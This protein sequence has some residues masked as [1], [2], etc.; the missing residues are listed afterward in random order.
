MHRWYAKAK[1][2]YVYLHDV[3][4]RADFE[5]S[6]WF[7]RGWTLQ[8][9]LAPPKLHFFNNDWRSIGSRAGLIARLETITRIPRPAINAF[10]ATNYC[11]AEKMSWSA[12]RQTTRE[13]DRAYCMLGL[14]GV[15]MPLLYGEGR[16]AFQRLQEEIMKVNTD[17][18]LFLWHG[19]ACDNFG[20][21][22][23]DPVCFADVPNVLQDSSS[24]EDIF[25]LSQGWSINNAG[26][27]IN[28]TIEPYALTDDLEA[29]FEL[30]LH[31]PC[32]FHPSAGFAILLQRE[33]PRL[34][35]YTYRRVVVNGSSY[36][37]SRRTRPVD[38]THI[39]PA[40][41]HV[42]ELFIT[43]HALE[44][45]EIDRTREFVFE[46]TSDSPV[47][48]SARSRPANRLKD[49]LRNWPLA[50]EA[51]QG[52]LKCSFHADARYAV[53]I[54]GHLVVTLVDEIEVLICLG[55][56]RGFQP[57]CVVLPFSKQIYCS[58]L[59]AGNIMSAYER[60]VRSQDTQ[61]LVFDPTRHMVCAGGSG[62]SLE[63]EMYAGIALEITSGNAV[64]HEILVEFRVEDYIRHYLPTV[65][66]SC[67]D[68][69]MCLRQHDFDKLVHLDSDLNVLRQENFE[70]F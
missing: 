24:L 43:R 35:G 53:G 32:T 31:E 62:G 37:R 69:L 67:S 65:D 30:Y 29:V 28:A 17:M 36:A 39:L 26:I 42:S 52:Y 22:A 6:S 4:G 25:K 10:A 5:N 55:L 49:R 46:F 66:L 15:N 16:R 19:H 38:L 58:R 63:L 8:E 21:L 60:I 54:L 50:R 61:Q 23:S 59:N 40:I 12:N 20:M 11:I 41:K 18:S 64:K 2:C 45:L 68:P 13:E 14:F 70:F 48:C 51:R 34:G 1:I 56:D 3:Q 27:R 33:E 57:L 47:R 44:E 7:T 9:L